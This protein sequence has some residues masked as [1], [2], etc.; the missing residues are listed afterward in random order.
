MSTWPERPRV[1]LSYAYTGDAPLN[2][3]QGVDVLIDSGAFTAHTSGRPIVL[4]DYIRFLEHELQTPITIIS[5]GPDRE[6]TIL[7][8]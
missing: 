3:P 7:R 1:L 8:R 5:V 6:Q 4:D 2:L